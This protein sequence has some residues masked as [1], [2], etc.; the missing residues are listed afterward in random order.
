MAFFFSPSEDRVFSVIISTWST[1]FL[2]MYC[3]AR[4]WLFLVSLADFKFVRSSLFFFLS[5][6]RRAPVYYCVFVYM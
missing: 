4:L 1:S 6:L 2:T 5:F 3:K